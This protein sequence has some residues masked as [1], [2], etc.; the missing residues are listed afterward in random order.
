ME[1]ENRLLVSGYGM[2][3]ML[4]SLSGLPFYDRTGKD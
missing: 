2:I 1:T 3:F 4:G